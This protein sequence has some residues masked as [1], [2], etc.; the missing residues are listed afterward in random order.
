MRAGVGAAGGRI[1]HHDL[2]R[3]VRPGIRGAGPARE[4]RGGCHGQHRATR[5][6]IPG[7]GSS[8]LFF[9][10]CCWMSD[11]SATGGRQAGRRQH[12]RTLVPDRL[13][14]AATSAET[15]MPQLH[16]HGL[17]ART[18]PDRAAGLDE[19]AAGIG[20]AGALGED[21]ITRSHI[22]AYRQPSAQAVAPSRSVKSTGSW[23]V[24]PVTIHKSMT[25]SPAGR[26]QQTRRLPS[27]GLSSGCGS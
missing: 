24:C 4:W 15:P 16:Q 1:G 14:Y 27:A 11:R 17:G 26:E 7:H 20:S 9:D 18:V 10:T 22:S 13:F 12:A 8:P 5:N 25:T 23:G 21:A 19:A 3:T 2:H 6:S